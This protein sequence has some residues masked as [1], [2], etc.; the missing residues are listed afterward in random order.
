MVNIIQQALIF[1]NKLLGPK[2]FINRHIKV[3]SSRH[4]R[5]LT[6]CGISRRIKVSN[7]VA[8][9]I[10]VRAMSSTCTLARPRCGEFDLLQELLECR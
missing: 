3:T 5:L 7:L 8:S 2:L 4:F 10:W 6:F 9:T 1:V